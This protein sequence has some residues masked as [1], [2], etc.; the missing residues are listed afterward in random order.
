MLGPGFL[1]AV[2]QAAMAE[3]LR[4]RKIPFEREVLLPVV[5]DGTLLTDVYDRV[6]FVANGVLVEL[7]AVRGLSGVEESQVLN[8]LQVRGAGKAL[9]LDFGAGRL[10]IR[11]YIA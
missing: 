7:K 6:D 10:E 11:R 1:E 8:S 2:Y 5:Y 9:L 3:E 4:R